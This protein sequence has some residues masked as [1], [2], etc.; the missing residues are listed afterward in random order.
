M[1]GPEMGPGTRA[2]SG[3][4]LVLDGKVHAAFQKSSESR[5]FRNGVS[6]R[7]PDR[8]VFAISEQ[9]V[10]FHEFALL[11]RDELQCRDALFLDGT[12]SS[13]FSER[14]RRN[15]RKMDLG[16]IIATTTEAR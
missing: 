15:D 4:L 8:V 14:L 5:L 2:Q 12:I 3:P 16:P 7:A 1:T 13:L 11:F 9:P 6:V 10:T